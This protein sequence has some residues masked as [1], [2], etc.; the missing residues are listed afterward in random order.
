MGIYINTTVAPLS[1]VKVR[2]AIAYAINRSEVSQKGE[3]GYEPP[4]N[5]TGVETPVFQSWYDRR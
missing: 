3:S 5:Q 1:D 2:Q 4:G